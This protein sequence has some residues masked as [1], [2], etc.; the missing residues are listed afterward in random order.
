MIDNLDFLSGEKGSNA[1]AVSGNH[2]LTG[3]SILA[4]DPHL[5][6]SIPGLWY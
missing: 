6:S 4:N 3:K 1:W 5:M 2:T